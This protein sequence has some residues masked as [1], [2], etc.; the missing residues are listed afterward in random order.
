MTPAL[1]RNILLMYW[2]M[3]SANFGEAVKLDPKTTVQAK[4]VQSIGTKLLMQS[5]AVMQNQRWVQAMLAICSVSALFSNELWSHEDTAC[6]EKMKAELDKTGTPMPVLRLEAVGK[7]VDSRNETVL[8]GKQFQLDITLHRDHAL[9]EDA[10]IP[11]PVAP[12][13]IYE[14]FL[15]LMESVMDNGKENV[16]LAAA[17]AIVKDLTQKTM[18]FPVPFAAPANPGKYTLRIHL[19][20]TSIVGIYASKDFQFEVVEDDVPSLE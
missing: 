10:E 1:R 2:V 11:E 20:T 4:I 16:L 14:A 7:G 17:P 8:P 6:I 5:Q 9:A 19:T 18:H 15:L 13:G 3:Y 12:G